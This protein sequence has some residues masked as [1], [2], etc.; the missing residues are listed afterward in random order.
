[1]F[2]EMTGEL[3]PKD[4]LERKIREVLYVSLNAVRDDL[5]EITRNESYK[6]AL[7]LLNRATMDEAFD[8][9]LPVDF[10]PMVEKVIEA[11]FEDS[12]DNALTKVFAEAV[13]KARNIAASIATTTAAELA[14]DEAVT[15][16]FAAEV[17]GEQVDIDEEAFNQNQFDY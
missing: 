10:E 13:S 15:A 9:D 3:G 5:Q 4:E 7:D 12:I 14:F 1:M 16:E 11:M 8:I 6:A 17:M 2:N